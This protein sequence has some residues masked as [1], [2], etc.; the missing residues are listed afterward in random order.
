MWNMSKKGLPGSLPNKIPDLEEPRAI[1]LLTKVT[2]IS[3]GPT[4]DVSKFAP[5]FVIQ[6]DPPFFKVEKY[7]DL[8]LTF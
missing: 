2:I 6:M 7:V 1:F 4:I 3:R 5:G 8:P